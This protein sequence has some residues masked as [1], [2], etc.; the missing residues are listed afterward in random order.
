MEMSDPEI[1][2]KQKSIDLEGVVSRIKYIMQL[3]HLSQRR[4][5]LLLR[6]DP[7]NLSKAMNGKMPFSEGLI[8]RMVVDL[9]VSKSWLRDGIGLPFDKASVARDIVLD[10]PM[11]LRREIQG[12]PVYDLDVTAG[13]RSLEDIF[14][15]TKPVGIID[16][17]EVPTG[18]KVIKVCGDSMYPRI[19]NGAYVAVRRIIDH[20]YIF[21]GQIYVVELEELR[22]VKYLRRHPDPEMIILHS[23]NPS[24]DDMDVCR[25]DIR[26]LYIVEAILNYEVN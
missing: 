5:A 23:D 25:C 15:E 19:A 24:Y 2:R 10:S 18:S 20:R 1:V 9:G 14:G 21:W 17:P 16:L 4:L 26:A 11:K 7:S 13:C 22:V 6:L 3:R 12:T 8:N